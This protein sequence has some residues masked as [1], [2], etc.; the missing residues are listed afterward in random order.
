VNW[1]FLKLEVWL[2][3]LCASWLL[4][5]NVGSFILLVLV[6][7]QNAAVLKTSWACIVHCIYYAF[8][9]LGPSQPINDYSP[10]TPPPPSG[11]SG[12]G[13]MLALHL[14]QAPRLR[15]WKVHPPPRVYLRSDDRNN[16][17][18][19]LPPFTVGSD[20]WTTPYR[21]LEVKMYCGDTYLLS[22]WYHCM[23]NSWL[24]VAAIIG[25]TCRILRLVGC[26]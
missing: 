24:S 17:I 25:L 20:G 14:H 1:L 23:L 9:V 26:V 11:W 6:T 16:F 18:R 15:W 12:G 2:L 3:V 5:Q 7:F 4:V 10:H 19:P 13:V 21:L 8:P 22:Y